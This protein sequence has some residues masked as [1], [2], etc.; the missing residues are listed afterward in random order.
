MQGKS[1]L[2]RYVSVAKLLLQLECCCMTVVCGRSCSASLTCHPS[3][4][5]HIILIGILV[6]GTSASSVTLSPDRQDILKE[7]SYA[8]KHSSSL[9]VE[10]GAFSSLKHEVRQQISSAVTHLEFYL[11]YQVRFSA[12]NNGCSDI[13]ISNE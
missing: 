13:F 10:T 5:P 7:V 1:L 3:N 6:V 4:S 2:D 8:N 12:M 11:E 9:P